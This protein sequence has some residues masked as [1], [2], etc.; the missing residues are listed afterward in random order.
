MHRGVHVG[1]ILVPL[2]TALGFLLFATF[3]EHWTRLDYSKIKQLNEDAL[4]SRKNYQVKQIRLSLPKYTG[5]FGECDEYKLVNLL[6][7]IKSNGD[8]SK[9]ESN[10]TEEK[11]SDPEA[12][13][14]SGSEIVEV[15][16]AEQLKT[17]DDCLT[18][19]KC[20]EL[21]RAQAQT[22]FCCNNLR[23]RDNN[24]E[25]ECCYYKKKKCDGVYDCKDYSDELNSNCPT[26][27]LYYSSRNYDDKSKCLRHDYN[28][29][30]FVKRL[31]HLDHVIDN[32]SNSITN[33]KLIFN[34]TRSENGEKIVL[35]N[36][37][38]SD[39]YTIRIFS[40]RLITLV[41]IVFC[42][43]F[44]ILCLL[45]LLCVTCCHNLNSHN[46]DEDVNKVGQRNDYNF[47][48]ANEEDFEIG[49][50][51][52]LHKKNRSCCCK[53]NCLLCPFAVFSF[54]SFF[55]FLAA[56]LALCSYVYSVLL[57]RNSY[58][59]FDN[60]YFPDHL[61]QAYQYN[62]W[63]FDMIKFGISFYA[64]LIS[65]L[66]YLLVLIMSTCISCRIQ[67]SPAWQNRNSNNYDL[68]NQTETNNYQ[69]LNRSNKIKQDT[70]NKNGSSININNN[71][72]NTNTKRSSKIY[73]KRDSDGGFSSSAELQA[74]SSPKTRITNENSYE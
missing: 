22:C 65:F 47:A 16:E 54:F 29:W 42:V 37:F 18:K 17:N 49:S 67:M 74:L 11:P 7:P 70:A 34:E 60:E 33:R 4:S 19:E 58:L 13:T 50:L 53:C 25:Y 51:A 68:L 21:N 31:F 8:E 63:L 45:T 23:R 3:T 20:E 15:A 56:L 55:A 38:M 69:L 73:N 57:V 64:M 61:I 39:S 6:E 14:S 72:S 43:F 1:F 27:K 24:D 10:E 9:P 30:Q 32:L 35:A 5:L 36:L 41:S 44:T 71:N 12:T 2:I 66:L 26:R 28:M 59:I 48:L 62:S 46:S 52:S 40:S